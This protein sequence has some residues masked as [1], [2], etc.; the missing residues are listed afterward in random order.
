LIH[1]YV[2]AVPPFIELTLN[3]TVVPSHTLVE[4]LAVTVADGVSMLST[5]MLR[6][7]VAIAG[8]A[9]VALLVIFTVTTSPFIGTYE[10]DE[11]V[12]LTV[13]PFTLHS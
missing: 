12:P 2:G 4:G 3:V 7:P 8:I 10:Y 11:V 5:L 6:A 13:V 1:V 9:H